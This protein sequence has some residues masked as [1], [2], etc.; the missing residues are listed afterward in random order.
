MEGVDE[1][2]VKR[3]SY[4]GQVIKERMEE[5]LD[6]IYTKKVDKYDIIKI[7]K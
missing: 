6:W 7:S 4:Y 5:W 2:Y 1:L 3:E